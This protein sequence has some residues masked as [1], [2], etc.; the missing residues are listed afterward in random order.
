L[1]KI[2]N[3]TTGE[4]I[5]TLV[6]SR[7]FD[8]IALFFLLFIATILVKD[9]P[10][11]IMAVI[12]LIA[13]FTLFLLITLILLLSTGKKFVQL[14]Q[15]TAEKLHM[16]NN[17]GVDYLIRKEFETVESLDK[18]QMKK[19]MPS[20]LASSL[21]IWLV[22]Y[23]LVYII[24]AGLNFQISLL[25]VILGGTFIVLT[26]ILPIQG[27]AGFGTTETVWTLVFVPLGLSI[28]QAI[29]SG[30]CFHIIM[31]LYFSVLGIYGAIKIKAWKNISGI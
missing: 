5:A 10:A 17:R 27:I 28:N 31:I 24:M 19:S 30:F 25:F 8:F 18:I 1:K 23:F 16:E 7:I 20:L 14:T 2:N 22:S 3:K 21:L 4:G 29:I 9:I 26:S 12:W 15:K 13:G 11:N 6:I